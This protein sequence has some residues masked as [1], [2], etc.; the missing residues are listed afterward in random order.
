VAGRLLR[1]EELSS[2]EVADLDREKT[3][4]FIPVSPIEGHG[5][6][7]PLGVDY[8]NAIYFAETIARITLEKRPDFDVV[9]LPIFPL[10]TQ[11]Y[12]QPGSIGISG[13]T[14]YRIIVSLGESIASSGF[15]H[16]FLLSGHGSPR[17]IVATESACLKVS[18][19]FKVKMHDLSGALAFRFLTG[20]FVDR[21]SA[22]L[23]QP[24]TQ[25]EK[26]LLRKDIHGGW[27]ETSMMLLL[28]PDLVKDSFRSLPSTQ[29]GTGKDSRDP[30]YFGS[31]SLATAAFAQA[32]M[33]VMIE[34]GTGTV[35]RCLSG[36][37]V[38]SET[39]SPFYRVL[40][41]RPFFAR[42]AVV[43]LLAII[44]LVIAAII[45]LT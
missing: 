9:L 13:I 37:N 33:R 24:L 28:R 31:P 21:I 30:G 43:I 16:I 1:L 36:E 11:V 38:L 8:Y 18:W 39:I 6:H 35:E 40:P 25:S 32:S 17:H 2:S 41:L 45:Y 19:K 23:P 15:R 44:V 34:E 3:A 14:L 12:R 29:K 22:Y 4:F 42:N 10:G 20:E 26:E 7:L 5:P 27:W